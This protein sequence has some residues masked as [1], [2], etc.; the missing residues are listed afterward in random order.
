MTQSNFIE[1]LRYPTAKPSIVDFNCRSEE[2]PACQDGQI[3][4]KNL[5]LSVDPYMRVRMNQK[6]SYMS[7][8]SLN[9]PLEGHCV[10]KVIASKSEQVQVGDLVTSHVY[11][12]RDHFIAYDNEVSVVESIDP[13]YLH[14]CTLGLTGMS[15]YIGLVKLAQPQAGETVFV[16]GA[17]GAVGNIVCQIAQLQGCQVIASAGSEEKINWLKDSLNIANVFNYKQGNVTEQLGDLAPNGIDIYFDN[18]GGDHLVAALKNINDFGRVTC[19]GM[20]SQY[21][22]AAPEINIDLFP[23]ISKRLKLQGFLLKDHMA[24]QAQFKQDMQ[25]WIKDGKI[26]TPVTIYEGVEKAANAFID[27]LNG[28]NQ[29]KMLI[30]V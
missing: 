19:C 25:Q 18:V 26:T 23:I 27:M 13:E 6:E 20:I 12:W 7:P 8:F 22:H 30:K 3:L 4:V 24:E 10:G 14:L 11:G 21:N 16:S 28:K 5:W 9:Q 1:L 29:G 2:L 17:A 15:A